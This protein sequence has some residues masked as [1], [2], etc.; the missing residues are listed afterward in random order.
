MAEPDG[1]T[2]SC[3]GGGGNE[4]RLFEDFATGIREWNENAGRFAGRELVGQEAAWIHWYEA[5]TNIGRSAGRGLALFL[6]FS[7]ERSFQRGCGSGEAGRRGDDFGHGR[8]RFR[9]QGGDRIDERPD[10]IGGGHSV[11]LQGLVVIEHPA[12]E[13]GRRRLLYPLIDE[14]GNFPPEICRVVQPRKLKTLQRSARSSLQVI[15]WRSETRNGH[16]QSSDLGVGPIR[17]GTVFMD[18]QY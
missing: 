3:S 11:G 18:A 6:R 13:H 1:D 16:G 10:Y 15:E 12:G 5:R 4:I 17:P 2:R 8:W 7:C 14:G 9:E